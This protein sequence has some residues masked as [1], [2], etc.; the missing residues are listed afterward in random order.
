M[1]KCEQDDVTRL[2]HFIVLRSKEIQAST[3]EGKV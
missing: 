2:Q 1:S 3:D